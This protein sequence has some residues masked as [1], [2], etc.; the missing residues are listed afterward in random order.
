MSSQPFANLSVR[1]ENVKKR[2]LSIQNRLKIQ[3][4]EVSKYD[5][6]EVLDVIIEGFQ[7]LQ[8][9]HTDEPDI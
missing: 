2:A 7:C 5:L 9:A 4:C 3:E 6:I 1:Y 8:W